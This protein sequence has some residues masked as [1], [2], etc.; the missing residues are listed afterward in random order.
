MPLIVC[1]ICEGFKQP[2]PENEEVPGIQACVCDRYMRK[3]DGEVLSF[4]VSE[5]I[6]TSDGMV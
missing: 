5:T 4:S 3:I 1:E 6:D 2:L